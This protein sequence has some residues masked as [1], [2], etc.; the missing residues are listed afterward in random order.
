MSLLTKASH[1]A[2]AAR[3]FSSSVVA[4]SKNERMPLVKDKPKDIITP[5]HIPLDYTG[6]EELA[7]ATVK[8]RVAVGATGLWAHYKRWSFVQ[9]EYCMYGLYHDD[10][11]KDEV[12]VVAEALRRLPESM[13]VAR[14]HRSHRAIQL[15]RNKALL[16]KEMW[17]TYDDPGNHYLQPY[18]DEVEKEDEERAK[19]NAM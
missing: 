5:E 19:W 16:P 8:Q 10:R 14:M 15:S 1:T 11:M 4:A 3:L 2:I 18:I 13:Y 9:D 12:P 7:Q 17:T 6:S